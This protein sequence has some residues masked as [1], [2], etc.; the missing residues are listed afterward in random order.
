MR[1][2]T[3]AAE[4][5][6][7]AGHGERLGQLDT[8]VSSLPADQGMLGGFTR[9]YI[10][11]LTATLRGGLPAAA[12]QLRAA[13][14]RT[15]RLSE[16]RSL[17]WAGDCAMLLQDSPAAQELYSRAVD[18]SR[19]LANIA[20]LMHALHL[21]ARCELELGK[22]AVAEA[23]AAEACQFGRQLRQPGVVTHSLAVLARVAALRG[24]I[25]ESRHRAAQALEHAIPHRLHLAVCAAVLAN[26]EVDIGLGRPGAALERL[27]PLIADPVA[28]P[29][30]LIELAAMTVEAAAH[31]RTP[32]RGQHALAL[33]EEWVGYHAAPAARA[34]LARCRGLLADSAQADRHFGEALRLLQEEANP[35]DQARTRLNFGEH[36]RRTGRRA[37][38]R[39][40]L[41]S[42]ME[43][44]DSLGA[45]LLADRAAEELRASGEVAQRRPLG[46]VGDLT[47]RERQVARLAAAGHSNGEV[48]ARLFLSQK[49]VEYHLHKVFTK[50]GMTSR[51]DL[52]A[53]GDQIGLAAGA[54]EGLPGV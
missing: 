42:A 28:H 50:L 53:A 15:A 39:P 49:T 16:E 4:A 27:E 22:V 24:D 20:D 34:T 38:A 46:A 21:R 52:A 30:Y 17:T 25:G 11:A 5:A 48:A 45:R 32:G 23:D 2:A 44:F 43:A 3:I 41:R 54:R 12:S 26:A 14:G 37:A 51:T 13:A 33:C 9:A 19:E 36:L 1:L 18:S 8:F 7:F 29:A 10:G 31:A 40:H 6:W 47:P 35:L